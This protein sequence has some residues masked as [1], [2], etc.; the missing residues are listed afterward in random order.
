MC[1]LVSPLLFKG[2]A[3]SPYSPLRKTNNPW[4]VLFPVMFWHVRG[5]SCPLLADHLAAV[6]LSTRV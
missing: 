2:F 4:T 1:N 5:I 6:M 3:E